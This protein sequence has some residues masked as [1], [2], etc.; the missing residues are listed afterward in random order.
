GPA[1]GASRPAWRGHQGHPGGR[2][3]RAEPPI[4]AAALAAIRGPFEAEAATRGEPPVVQPL[5]LFL[6]M[7]G[8]AMRARLFVVQADGREEA[9][10]RPELT[11]PVARAH[12]AAG[13]A[14]GRYAYEGKAFRALPRGGEATHAEE[15]LQIG[16]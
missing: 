16:L 7:A 11:I 15:F 5:N 12:V 9:C 13:A 14:A 4:P 10:L 8:E 2:A 6:D 3:M 1:D